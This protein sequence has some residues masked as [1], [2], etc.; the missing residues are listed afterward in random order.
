MD[1]FTL[2]DSLFG[3][4]L[5]LLALIQITAHDIERRI[6]EVLDPDYDELVA[7][8]R[9]IFILD[10]S[11]TYAGIIADYIDEHS[12]ELFSTDLYAEA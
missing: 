11:V 5:V 8:E 2:P 1:T 12:S 9:A 7:I 4:H 6:D 10:A 3:R